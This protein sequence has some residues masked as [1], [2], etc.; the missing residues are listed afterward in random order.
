VIDRS[1]LLKDLQKQTKA[2]EASL[3]ERLEEVPA[4][5]AALKDEHATAKKEGRTGDAY[6]T[7]LDLRL[8]QV[9][10]SWVLATVF[11]R[12]LEDNEL[13]HAPRLAGPGENLQRARDAEIVFFRA[14]PELSQRELLEDVFRSYA[15][16]PALERIL[17]EGHNPLWLVRP[18]AN[19]AKALLEFWRRRDPDTGKLIHD[20][21]DP[22][23]DTRFLGDLYQDLSELIR[24]RYALL[25]TPDFVERFILDRTL[26]PA[27][28]EFGLENTRLIDPA[29][30]SG[31]FLLGAFE[32]FFECWVERE[33]GTNLRELAQRALRGV[34][35][36]DLNPFA[37]AI[38]RFRLVLAALKACEITK[39]SQ[40][41]GFEF[42]LAAGDSL[43][44]GPP[45]SDGGA[46]NLYLDGMNP[47]GHLD[48]V[49]DAELL[50]NILGRKYHAVV[51]NPPYITPKDKALNVAYRQIFKSCHRKYSLA[52]PFKER[53]FDL[54]AA[55]SEED[56]AGFVG[57]I[58]A[59][60]FM[61]REFGKK[62][63]EDPRFLAG[64]DLT[65]V[66]DTSGAYIPGHGTPTVILLG[67][68]RKP[69][70][71][72]IRA[73]R[74]IQGEPCTPDEPAEGK[75][76]TSVTGLV[77]QPGA[78]NDFVSVDDVARDS[79]AS[80]PWSMTG[81]GAAELKQELESQSSRTL[82][83]LADSIGF[84]SFTGQ[85]EAFVA[86]AS[87]FRRSCCP[88][89]LV[90]PFV[91]GEVVRDWSVE[92]RLVA[93][94]PYVEDLS[95]V[96]LQV[97]A[98]WARRL[99]PL[100]TSLAGVLSFGGKTRAECGDLWWTWYRWV[101]EKYRTKFTITFAF[102]ATHNHFV[103][104]RG[105]KVFSR[106]APVIKL[107]ADAS[108][109]DHLALL[110][111]LN[112]STLGFWLRQVIF[113][114]GAG[115]IGGGYHAEKWSRRN[116]YDGTKLSMAPICEG[117]SLELTQEILRTVDKLEQSMPRAVLGR[118]GPTPEDLKRAEREAADQRCRLISLQEELDWQVYSLYGLVD[119]DLL[120]D[121]LANLPLL[122]L[123]QR[124]FEISMARELPNRE[125]P[126][127]W[128]ERHGAEVTTEVPGEW[129]AEY[130]DLVERRLAAIQAEKRI[131]LLEAPEYKRRWG[132][133]DWAAKQTT[134]I[135]EWLLGKI[136][137][138]TSWANVG[139]ES[140]AQIAD[141][142]RGVPGFRELAGVLRDQQDFDISL[143]VEELI[144]AEAVPAQ[145]KCC[146]KPS[147]LRKREAWESVWRLQRLEDEL[148]A[149]GLL[150]ED[151]PQRLS[152]AQLEA[153]KQ[154]QV[155]EIPVPPR[156]KSTDFLRGN[157]W[158]LR[159]KLDVPKER[160]I[161]FPGAERDQDPTPVFGWAGWDHL[162]RAQAIAAYYLDRKEQDGWDATRLTPLLVALYELL[163]W[164]KQWHNEFDPDFGTGLGDYYAGFVEEEARSLELTLADL[165]NW[166]PPKELLKK[167]RTKKKRTKKKA[168]KKR[169]KKA[170]DPSEADAG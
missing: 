1:A 163:P 57:L 96:D 139:L 83:D 167:K 144:A 59:N 103:L 123:G 17:G 26:D 146:Y 21:T 12:F 78:E 128:F 70:A 159:G 170:A 102:V 85:D 101:P 61:K 63:I 134:A 121:D 143:L 130:R 34:S 73:V 48:P 136:E 108:E 164:L 44:H 6:T 98:P 107:P 89:E 56:A 4:E 135:R 162:E 166:D 150:P 140:V 2:I 55:P 65:H 54:A 113:P 97:E 92:E 168:S 94:A 60:S 64:W 156:Y 62:L 126:T 52:V 106:S 47:L 18:T 37:I 137:E 11:V 142:V 95:P 161:S 42:D 79:L 75:V 88:K 30:G 165:E 127:A 74:G 41:P 157:Y 155:G 125:T 67:R 93:F 90:K 25:Q 120:L 13:G 28:E 119:S 87:H 131:R 29:C 117:L 105:G 122:C 76:W 124:P 50:R 153:A 10:S 141:R 80:H 45:P 109:E 112:S 32:R 19:G 169:T 66:I 15:K 43:L 133:F 39:L 8:S 53:C 114:K 151:D 46:L 24:K 100:R 104:D 51:A 91:F 58:T 81:G 9:A 82:G 14:H 145:V 147:G 72:T 116:E 84:A 68:S 111:L 132:K 77:D 7:W 35:G 148:D 154:A 38:A 129:S 5:A 115:G 160:F 33:P 86:D 71:P 138:P 36:V 31:H 110:G 40:A 149:R 16:L 99:W 23:R 3:R 49:E 118:S 22:A 152:Q 158:S 20:F 27:I 69:V